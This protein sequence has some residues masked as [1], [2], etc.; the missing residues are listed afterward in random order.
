M[1]RPF[2]LHPVGRGTE[3]YSILEHLWQLYQ[4][5]LSEFRGDHRPQGI[6][7]TLPSDGGTYNRERL[8]PYIAGQP[9]PDRAAYLF[10]LGASPAG[11]AFIRGLT[12]EAALMSEFFIV[13]GARGEGVG[14]AATAALFARHPGRWVIPFQERNTPA[15]RFWRAVAA[16]ASTVPLREERRPVPRK[17]EV[18]PDV[19][20][21]IIV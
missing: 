8:L 20:L 1:T 7:R 4:H 21:T 17:P 14:R 19:W 15:A 6:V 16:A 18:P 10:R 9:D 11:F 5:D 12:S 2:S 3:Q 13:R